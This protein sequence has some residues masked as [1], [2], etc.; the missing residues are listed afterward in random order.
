MITPREKAMRY[1]IDDVRRTVAEARARST[2]QWVPGK[3]GDPL[4]IQKARAEFDSSLVAPEVGT[5]EIERHTAAILSVE[6]GMRRVWFLTKP[7]TQRVFL[8]EGAGTFGVAW[9][10]DSATGN[11][12]DLGF[13]TED[14]IDA[15]LA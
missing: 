7:T 14:P 12:V 11:Y 4:A 1:T 10:P 9:G 13:R 2:R 3:E 8:D 15:F 5:I 6:A